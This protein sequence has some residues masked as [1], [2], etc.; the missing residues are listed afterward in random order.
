MPYRNHIKSKTTYLIKLV[1]DNIW[2][3]HRPTLYSVN[4]NHS[5]E[6]YPEDLSNVSYRTKT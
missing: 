4:D 1:R 5:V 3:L 6:R 2:R